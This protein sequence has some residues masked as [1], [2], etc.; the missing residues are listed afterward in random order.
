MTH[1]VSKLSVSTELS[2]I[3]LVKVFIVK[4]ESQE[5]LRTNVTN[6]TNVWGMD[7]STTAGTIKGMEQ[8]Q[9]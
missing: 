2:T 1:L 4:Q 8:Q 7:V 9:Q 3:Q 6:T 5:N